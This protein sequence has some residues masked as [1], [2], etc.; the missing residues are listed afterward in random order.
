MRCGRFRSRREEQNVQR[1]LSY[2]GEAYWSF[3]SEADRAAIAPRVEAVLRAG[4][5]KSRRDR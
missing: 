4:M 3:I 5:D 2:L 1:I